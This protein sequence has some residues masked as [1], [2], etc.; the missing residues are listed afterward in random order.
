MKIGRSNSKQ[1]AGSLL[2][3]LEHAH[4][5]MSQILRRLAYGNIKTI[6]PKRKQVENFTNY[7]DEYF[8][9]T[10]YTTDCV[11]W[12]KAPPRPGASVEEQ[13]N[14][15]ITAL[16]PGSSVHAVKALELVRWEDYEME[17]VNDNDF[18]WFVNG[19]TLGDQ[20]VN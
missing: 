3:I 16:W 7:C 14:A 9:C 6:E 20:K 5:Y 10:V 4:L 1:G 8:K 12:Y 15:R 13:K 11:S 18:G 2:V 19:W 17:T